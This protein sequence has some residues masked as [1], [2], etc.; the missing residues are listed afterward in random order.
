MLLTSEKQGM[1]SCYVE[2]IYAVFGS[3]LETSIR[4]DK[5]NFPAAH[6]A[7][8]HSQ[9]AQ[10]QDATHCCDCEIGIILFFFYFIL[11]ILQKIH[12]CLISV[13]CM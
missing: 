13:L 7:V 1:K 5:L 6:C 10:D 12:C 3:Q 2:S 9:K 8:T 4:G 11:F